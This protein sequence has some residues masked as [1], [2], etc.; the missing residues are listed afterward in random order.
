MDLR[1]RG[2]MVSGKRLCGK[3][4]VLARARMCWMVGD[5]K[6]GGRSSPASERGLAPLIQEG[7]STGSTQAQ[8]S[9]LK[10]IETDEHQ[11]KCEQTY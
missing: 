2:S 6:E 7:A 4:G 3:Y 9:I 1:R 5:G 10:S 11:R 8:C